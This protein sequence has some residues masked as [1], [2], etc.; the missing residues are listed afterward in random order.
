M[1]GHI[2]A[3]LHDCWRNSKYQVVEGRRL[4]WCWKKPTKSGVAF[5]M[6]GGFARFAP[7]TTRV[8]AFFTEAC[9]YAVLQALFLHIS[10]EQVLCCKRLV[11]VEHSLCICHCHGLPWPSSRRL[12]N[13][14]RQW[15]NYATDIL[16][17][18][19]TAAFLPFFQTAIRK[20]VLWC[21]KEGT[22][23]VLVIPDESWVVIWGPSHDSL[24]SELWRTSLHDW[25]PHYEQKLSWGCFLRSPFVV[26]SVKDFCQCKF[27]CVFCLCLNLDQW[28]FET[29]RT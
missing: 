7:L 3:M 20:S 5:V 28:S 24:P 11:F 26:W 21:I 14:P 10:W 9:L 2:T 15:R 27:H 29:R 12:Q 19:I 18:N 13:H 23:S 4:P 25:V 16:I 8:N 6:G 17:W 22:R 1:V